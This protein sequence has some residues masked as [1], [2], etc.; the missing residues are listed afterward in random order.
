MEV[1]IKFEPSGR[2]GIVAVGSYLSEAARRLGVEI[3][4]ETDEPKNYPT[5]VVNVT[6]G[7]DLLSQPT[8]LEIEHLTS[9]RRERGDRLAGQAKIERA[10]DITVMVTKKKE[11]ESPKTDKKM[12]DFR[13]EFADLP[14]E[15]KVANLL[16]MEAVTIGETFSFVINSPFKIFEKVMDVMAE[17]GLKLEND[18]KKA[19]RPTEHKPKPEQTA[20]SA[21]K[22]NVKNGTATK[23]EPTVKKTSKPNNESPTTKD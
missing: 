5:D 6:K 2:N 15:K 12:E 14:L 16:E 21:A 3:E 18:A 10:G 22:E 11:P 13:K 19:T 1:I 7:G 20:K 4:N 9:K 8:K 23:S 17:F